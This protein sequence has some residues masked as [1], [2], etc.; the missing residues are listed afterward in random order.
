MGGDFGS[1][2]VCFGVGIAVVARMSSLTDLLFLSI[3]LLIS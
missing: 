3:V 2:I 1:C